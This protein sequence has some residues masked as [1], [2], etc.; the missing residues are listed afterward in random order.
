[1]L[2]FASRQQRLFY[3]CVGKHLSDHMSLNPTSFSIPSFL[4]KQCQKYANHTMGVTDRPEVCG[5]D[6]VLVRKE[7]EVEVC[8]RD[9]KILPIVATNINLCF[10]L[11][12]EDIN[13]TKEES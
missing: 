10:P 6:V 7:N 4:I 9:L 13:G 3:E 2:F 8:F 11:Y 5:T 12:E 1:M